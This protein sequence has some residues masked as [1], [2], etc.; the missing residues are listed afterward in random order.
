MKEFPEYRV[1]KARRCDIN[2]ACAWI[3]PY[4]NSQ[5]LGYPRIA[6]ITRKLDDGK[7]L[8]C[9]AQLRTI[10]QTVGDHFLWNIIK[11]EK[12]KIILLSEYY[13]NIIG[14]ENSK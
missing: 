3:S 14:I 7:E 9:Y 12:R 6:R 5:N 10:D 2:L 13:I 11:N 1:Y 4:T 8:Y